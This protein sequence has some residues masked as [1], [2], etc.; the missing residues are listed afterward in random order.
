MFD[1]SARMP[2]NQPPR[3]TST[4]DSTGS[5]ECRITLSAKSRFQPR[6]MFICAPPVIGST[7]HR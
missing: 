6:T 1:T 3:P 7:G 5:T 2:M 4:S